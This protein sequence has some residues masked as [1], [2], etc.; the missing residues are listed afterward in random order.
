MGELSRYRNKRDFQ[1]TREPSG[2]KG[3]RRSAGG[4]FVVQKH[5]ARRLHYDLRLEMDGVLRSWAVPKGFD[6]EWTLV[7]TKM[8]REKEDNWRRGPAGRTG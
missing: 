6:V 5:D 7:R 2:R 4:A 8:G 1:R 3:R